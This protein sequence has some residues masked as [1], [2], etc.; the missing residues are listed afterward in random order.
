LLIDARRSTRVDHDGVPVLLGEQDRS[1]WDST[2]IAQ[3]LAELGQA[4]AAGVGGPYQFQAAIAALHAT[5]PS[6]QQTAWTA[7]VGLYDALLGRRATAVLA[8]NRAVALSQAEGPAAGL[9]ALDAIATTEDLDG[10]LSDYVY[11]HSARAEMLNDLGEHKE[12]ITAFD[13]ALAVCGNEAERTHL[14]Q[15]RQATRVRCEPS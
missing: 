4:H 13:R 10:D 9:A 3:G 15:R 14:Q 1:Q 11:F 12:S 5:A 7:I 2:K 6:L 8:L